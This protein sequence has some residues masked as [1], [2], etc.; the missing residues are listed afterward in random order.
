MGKAPT[1]GVFDSGVGGLSIFATVQSRIRAASMLYCSDNLNFPYGTRTE[2]DVT[3]CVL[4]A[5]TRF[6]AKCSLDILVIA[7]NTAS[8][9]ALPE[10]R[11]RLGIPVVGVVPAIKPAANLS[12][13]GTIALLATPGTVARPYTDELIQQF[14]PTCKVL[15]HGSS[16][17]VHAAELKLR[18][19]PLDQARMQAEVDALF[20][21]SP[22]EPEKRL[23]QVVLGCTHFPLLVDELRAASPWP[24]GWIDSSE[25][26][27][28]RTEY[29]CTEKGYVRDA[30]RRT[31]PVAYFTKADAGAEQLKPA[32]LARGFLSIDVL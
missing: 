3:L 32:L 13:T 10:L 19:E 31:P 24:V 4:R 11:A 16:W 15:K 2:A 29:L 27:A 25:A 1:I 7:C 26:V 8:T 6:V 22:L 30:P 17:L 21:G 20:A 14:A 23:D 28:A 9:V 5:T 18:G 12:R